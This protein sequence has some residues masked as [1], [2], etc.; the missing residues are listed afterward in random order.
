VRQLPLGEVA[1]AADPN[2]IWRSTPRWSWEAA[3]AARNPKNFSASS[4]QAATHRASMVRL[5]S[6]TQV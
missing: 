6:R 5:A 3:A 4:G 2:M 1:L